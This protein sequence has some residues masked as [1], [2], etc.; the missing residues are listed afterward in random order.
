MTFIEIAAGVAAVAAVASTG[1]A[2]YSANEQATAQREMA[3]YNRKI[4]EFNADRQNRY[5]DEQS[6]Q[7]R[8]QAN[9][10][11][12]QRDR[13]IGQ[14]RAQYA[15]AGVTDQGSPLAVLADTYN[16]YELAA[17]E[18]TSKG[19]QAAEE[20][21]YA[22]AYDRTM[23]GAGYRIA[24]RQAVVTQA[25]GYADAAAGVSTMAFSYGTSMQGKNLAGEWQY[26]RGTVP[27]ATAVR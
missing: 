14:Q 1:I 5:A 6:R 27:R 24:M 9:R 18:Q 16:Q 20:I 12:Q 4:A 11:R 13:I 8:E 22:A 2:L 3:D 26:N 10:I 17:A 15:A 21:K 23:A 25:S 19:N 7:A